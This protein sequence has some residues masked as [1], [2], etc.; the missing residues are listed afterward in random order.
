MTEVLEPFFDVKVDRC[1]Y[2]PRDRTTWDHPLGDEHVIPLGMGGVRQLLNASCKEHEKVTSRFELTVM[3]QGGLKDLREIMGFPSRRAKQRTGKREV[4]FM[5]GDKRRT[6]TVPLNQH[7]G[8]WVLPVY[9][10]PTK[11]TGEEPVEDVRVL[12]RVGK[13]REEAVQKLRERF[14][15]TAYVMSVVDPRAWAQMMAKIGYCFAVGCVG[16][17][18]FEEIYVLPTILNGKLLGHYLG[19]LDGLPVNT[20]SQG[21]LVTMSQAQQELTVHVRLFAQMEFPEY[22]VVVGRLRDT[23]YT[24]RA[25]SLVED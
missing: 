10:P 19:W 4:T 7:P 15:I 2:C 9:A 17:D 16:L 24:I 18:T 6:E 25:R 3:N 5:V 14:G 20:E 22:T 12:H 1:I 11:L 23:T 21:N 8:G 13:R